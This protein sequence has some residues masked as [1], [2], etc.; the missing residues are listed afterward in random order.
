[1]KNRKGKSRTS[2]R[3][4][5]SH[6]VERICSVSMA[7]VKGVPFKRQPQL[8]KNKRHA[9]KK[10]QQNAEHVL[11]EGRS[12]AYIWED[13]V[14][15]VKNIERDSHKRLGNKKEA[16]QVQN[17]AWKE[18]YGNFRP[19]TIPENVE[20]KSQRKCFEMCWNIRDADE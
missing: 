19:E 12:P 8:N 7:D 11:V 4:E 18:F 9:Y 20:Y 16:E 10:L 13:N 6:T 3:Q 5:S 14:A 1:M 15:A 2:A 17:G